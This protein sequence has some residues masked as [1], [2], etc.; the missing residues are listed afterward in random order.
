[1]TKKRLGRIATLTTLV[2]CLAACAAK[3]AYKKGQQE[4]K[5][6]T[7]DAAVVHFTRATRENPDNIEYRMALQRALAESSKVHLEEGRK[8]LAAENL[9]GAIEELE[10]ALQLDPTNR[11]AENDLADARAKLKEVLDTL[12]AED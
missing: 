3:S 12:E 11:Y 10:L 4:A 8:R 7:W 2:I 1:M 5:Q 6:H 9:E